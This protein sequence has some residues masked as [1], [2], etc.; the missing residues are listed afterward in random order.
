MGEQGG[1]ENSVGSISVANG[2]ASRRHGDRPGP[3][4]P[5]SLEVDLHVFLLLVLPDVHLLREG[6]RDGAAALLLRGRRGHIFLGLARHGPVLVE[7]VGVAHQERL[8]TDPSHVALAGQ[9]PVDGDLE[10]Y[11][12]LAF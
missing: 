12:V 11:H 4:W 10:L 2:S 6:G 1:Q 8:F 9:K 3:P 5:R 7:R